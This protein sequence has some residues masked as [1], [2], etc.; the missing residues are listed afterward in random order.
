M[1]WEKQS[2]NIRLPLQQGHK[3]S[4]CRGS[5]WL[6]IW[7]LSLCSTTP[8]FH[9]YEFCSHRLKSMWSEKL[10]RI[11]KETQ[12]VPQSISHCFKIYTEFSDGPI[13]SLGNCE[14][15]CSGI[16]YMLYFTEKL[17]LNT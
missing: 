17:C 8:P 9:P 5:R 3:L 1:V 2:Q 7:E 15:A 11:Q 13:R 12:K 10:Q 14:T 6:S 16:L 4:V